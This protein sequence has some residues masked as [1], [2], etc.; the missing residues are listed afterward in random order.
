MEAAAENMLSFVVLDRPNPW[1]V[2]ESK[3]PR[4]A[5]LDFFVSQFPIPYVTE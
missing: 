2:C 4:G 5:A 3:A 1:A